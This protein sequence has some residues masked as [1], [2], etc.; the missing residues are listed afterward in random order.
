MAFTPHFL[1]QL[2]TRVGLVDIIAKR[3]KLT[4][5]GHEYQGL[6]PFH[7]EKTPS[8]TV[9]EEK[10][11]YHCFG[12]QANGGAIDFIMETEG[13][14]FPET[15]QRLAQDVGMEIPQD[16]P[17]QREQERKRKS[18]ADVTEAA[19]VFFEKMLH[20][21]EG[22]KAKA[23]LAQ[24]GLDS[25]T[26]SQFR[27]G[28]SP[29]NRSALK[30]ALT[31]EGIGEDLM[32]AA[33]LLIKPD[34][35]RDPYDRFRGRVMFPIADRRGRV[36]AFGGRI[37][38]DGEPK[39]LNSP[40]TVL[41]HKGHVLY[42]LDKAATS[43]RSADCLLVTEGYMDV[44]A[45]AQAGFPYAVAPLGTALTEDQI[46]LLWQVVPEPILCFDGDNAGQRAASRASERALPLMV[47]G[48]SIRFATLPTGEDPDS[49]IKTQG[50]AAMDKII[51]DALPLS[52]VLW[53]IASGGTLPKTPEMRATLQKTLDDYVSRIKDPTLRRHFASSYTERLWPNQ[54]TPPPYNN[55][56]SNAP[57]RSWS[58]RKDW[59]PGKR[60]PQGFV[61]TQVGPATRIDS[62]RLTELILLA[63][64]INNTGLY[65]D[66]S[67]DLGTIGFVAD[68]LDK[69]RQEV[70]KTLAENPALE[71]EALTDHLKTC[72]Y[73]TILP[74]ILSDSVYDHAFFAR[75]ET[76][77]GDT[78]KGWRQTFNR[79]KNS[80]L[81][82][83]I[84]DA[85]K[86]FA[87]NPT[88]EASQRLLILKQ[89]QIEAALEDPETDSD[90]L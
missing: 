30:T 68:D 84:R 37:M 20:M 26:I 52:E 40:E 66:V 4:R 67:E 87:E 3:V 90:L 10:G 64:L 53:N 77:A 19:C 2:K 81:L 24:R 71:T 36:I 62:H 28:F 75:S 78:A 76:P 86:L 11:F 72:G 54:A 9:N 63:T 16:T 5:K 73:A 18:L 58:E 25:H 31:R 8:F 21:P 49:L 34:N 32:I 83:E 88:D 61:K 59:S 82:V 17:E 51:S 42:G 23:Y 33:G 7:K 41:F 50:K 48:K 13:L 80:A 89:Q 79:L 15:V 22:R 29:D 45:L 14:S 85:E 56:Y 12:C 35:N 39:Y 74:R 6:C 65:D 70:L 43:A 69:I 55:G 60:K 57:S 38:G 46:R 27:L 47:P 44:I 1:D